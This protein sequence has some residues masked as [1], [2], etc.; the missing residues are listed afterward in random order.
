MKHHHR[1]AQLAANLPRLAAALFI[2]HFTLYISASASERATGLLLVPDEAN[3]MTLMHAVNRLRA[4]SPIPLDLADGWALNTVK[5][6]DY[7]MTIV[8]GVTPT[9]PATAKTNPHNKLLTQAWSGHRPDPATND[10]AWALKTISTKPLV[11]AATGNRPRA[12][13]YAVWELADLIA[14]GKDLTALNRVETPKLPKRYTVIGAHSPASP[15]G[16]PQNR[17]TLF[18]TELDE[19]PRYGING[20]YLCLGE[21]RVGVGPGTVSLPLKMD[22][23]GNITLNRDTYPK[24][25]NM[26]EIIKSY[27]FEVITTIDPYIPPGYDPKQ[28]EKY[29]AASNPAKMPDTFLADT[30]KFYTR[31]IDK[32][33]EAFPQLDG[34]VFHAGVEGANHSD[35][36][37]KV[38]RTF[39]YGQ[40]V[41]PCSKVMDTYLALFDRALKKY[42][43][44]G[45]FRTHSF[46]VTSESILAMREELF[47]HPDITIIE[48]AYWPNEVW[49]NGGGKIPIMAYLDEPLRARVDQH[50]K[51]GLFVLSDAE[52]FGGG[53]LPNAIDQCH[54]HAMQQLLERNSDFV[55]FRTELHDRTPFGTLWSTAGIQM[56]QAAARLWDPAIPAQDVW[57]RWIERRWGAQAAPY[58]SRA[59]SNNHS[60][61]FNGLTLDGLNGMFKSTISSQQW[62]PNW[63]AGERKMAMFARPGTHLLKKKPAIITSTDQFSVQL[64]NIAMPFKEFES[65]QKKASDQ[66]AFSL[67]QIEQARPW[68][69]KT[70][71]L[72]LTEIFNNAQTLIAVIH[73]MA[74]AAY[75]ANLTKDNFDNNPDPKTYFE[76]S[77]RA[78]EARAASKDVQWLAANR[79]HVYGDIPA[80]LAKIAAAYRKYVEKK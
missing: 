23:A 24:W 38:V 43:I 61:I 46:G 68:L 6:A 63:L 73:D 31:Y 40:D 7:A 72:Y 45:Y 34:L 30:E 42:A 71:Y 3:A 51:L 70:D 10:E 2:I 74:Q 62:M 57:T 55:V 17:H 32:L 78:L 16:H 20:I 25:R 77:I 8:L 12:V 69:S 75:A 52:Y 49:I 39:L 66:I 67:A 11:I 36:S 54:I 1:L 64:N 21:F 58:I 80:E 26:I 76:T 50:N 79:K 56:E 48:D 9:A 13:L 47:K 28:V 27:D 65:R 37:F 53:S 15:P 33:M 19:L 60:I 44:K 41:R 59:L 5:P 14:M 35:A 22:K 18:M 4:K 29:Y